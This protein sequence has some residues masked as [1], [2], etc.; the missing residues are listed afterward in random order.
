MSRRALGAL[1]STAVIISTL[2]VGVTPARAQVSRCDQRTDDRSRVK[3]PP[4]NGFMPDEVVSLPSK[5]D[6]AAI[7][8]GIVRPRVPAGTRV[9]VLH[10]AALIAA[11]TQRVDPAQRRYGVDNARER[12]ELRRKGER[13]QH[14]E[15]D[16]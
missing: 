14:A 7:H 13:A 8:V 3:L 16:E 12:H 2:T 11:T 4:K 15:D 6:G 9:Q 1:C 5:I 10:T